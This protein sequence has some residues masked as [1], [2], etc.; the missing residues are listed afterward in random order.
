MDIDI[1]GYRN[2]LCQIKGYRYGIGTRCQ[3]FHTVILHP[4]RQVQN[5][6]HAAVVQY[7]DIPWTIRIL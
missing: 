7:A 1:R 4:L 2:I 6:R 3:F 5:A